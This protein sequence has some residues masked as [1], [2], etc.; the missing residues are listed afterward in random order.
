ML[1]TLHEK[2]LNF[3]PNSQI[4]DPTQPKEFNSKRNRRRDMRPRFVR[5]RHRGAWS[6]GRPRWRRVGGQPRLWLASPARAW[7]WPAPCA[8]SA[9]SPTSPSPPEARNPC[10]SDR[11]KPLPCA[12]RPF[13]PNKESDR[14]NAK[15]STQIWMMRRRSCCSCYET[16]KVGLNRRTTEVRLLAGEGK[17]SGALTCARACVRIA[18]HRETRGR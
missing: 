16:A 10:R 9:P 1:R 14:R 13:P 7:P 4:I 17:P 2:K 6:A 5:A 11:I 12:I 8:P 18:N 3:L 15:K